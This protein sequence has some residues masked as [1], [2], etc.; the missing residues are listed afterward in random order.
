MRHVTVFSFHDSPASRTSCR[1]GDPAEGSEFVVTR[2]TAPR[3]VLPGG[4]SGNEKRRRLN[5][6]GVFV[7]ASEAD[8]PKVDVG[9]PW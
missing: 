6:A 8:Q 5:D 3:S 4:G 7:V 1:D 9:L 2:R